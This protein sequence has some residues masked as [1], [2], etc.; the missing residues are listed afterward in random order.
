M[1]A[2]L[3]ITFGLGFCVTAFLKTPV[4]ELAGMSALCLL[5]GMMQEM[6]G[7]HSALDALYFE[8]YEDEKQGK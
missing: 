4:W 8:L 7:I 3:G 2:I 6:A 1:L 5:A